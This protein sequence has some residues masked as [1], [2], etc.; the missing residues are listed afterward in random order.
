MVTRA[1]RY[2]IT[3]LNVHQGLTKGG[4]LPHII[5]DMVVESL[6]RLW[7]TLVVGEE[8]GPYSFRQVVQ[9]LTTLFYTGDGHGH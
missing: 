4:P 1:E 2:Y 6:I 7:V 5:F 8:A 9:W 3:P